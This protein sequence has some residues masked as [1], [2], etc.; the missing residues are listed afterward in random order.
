MRPILRRQRP[1]VFNGDPKQLAKLITNPERIQV[2]A[3]GKAFTLKQV[4]KSK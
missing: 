2:L 4:K 3:P 1:T